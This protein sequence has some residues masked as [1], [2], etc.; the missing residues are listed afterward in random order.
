MCLKIGSIKSSAILTG[1][2]PMLGSF[3]N[4]VAG[5]KVQ[6]LLKIDSKTGFS[7]GYCKIFKKSFLIYTTPP[8]AASESPITV[9]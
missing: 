8:V 3:Y 1:K 5:I 4:K 6:N 2:T 9:Q 7:W